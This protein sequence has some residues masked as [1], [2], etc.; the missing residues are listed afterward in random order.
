MFGVLILLSLFLFAILN[1]G[2]ADKLDLKE[3]MVQS[4]NVHTVYDTQGVQDVRG[5]G[6]T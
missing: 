3:G 5:V 6:L 1:M 4:Q 2:L